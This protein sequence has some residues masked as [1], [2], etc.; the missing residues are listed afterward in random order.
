MNNKTEWDLFGAVGGV[1][2]SD[3]KWTCLNPGIG[4]ILYLLVK[5]ENKEKE[6]MND[7]M[8]IMIL[9]LNYLPH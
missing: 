8:K 4:Y 5:D 1:V 2:T 3:T 6:A 9:Q 7:A